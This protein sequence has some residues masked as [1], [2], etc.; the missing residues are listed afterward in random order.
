MG[1]SKELCDIIDEEFTQAKSKHA[2]LKKI[3]THKISF[4]EIARFLLSTKYLISHTTGHLK[5]AK[6]ATDEA[7]LAEYFGHHIEE[8]TGHEK[9]AE[10]D[11][12]FLT[13]I[14]S[15]FYKKNVPESMTEHVEWI[16]S[17]IKK[18]VKLYLPYI[19]FAEYIAVTAGPWFIEN[20][21]LVGVPIKALSVVNNHAV[22][23]LEHIKDD[24]KIIDELVAKEPQYKEEFKAIIHQSLGNYFAFLDEIAA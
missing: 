24:F 20:T 5:I 21:K 11:L 15:F 17:T 4:S 7:E 18:D 6:D 2:F 9:W 1:Y 8:E 13:K 22:L 10:R 23:D 12:S 3:E 16:E 14:K 19:L